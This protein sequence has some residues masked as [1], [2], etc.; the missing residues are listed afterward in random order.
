MGQRRIKTRSNGQPI[1]P[2]W[3][4][5]IFDAIQGDIVPR[6]SVGKVE[7]LSGSIGSSLFNWMRAYIAAGDFDCGDFKL[8]HSYNGAVGP[9]QG[10]MLCD[11]R[12]INEANYNTEHGAGSWDTY[13][14]SSPLDGKYLP[15]LDAKY[16]VGASTTTQSGA[17]P[18]T[19][20]GNAGNV[21][22]LSHNHQIYDVQG[23]NLAG[24]SYA[25]NNSFIDLSAV[26]KSGAAETITKASNISV[27]DMYT[28]KHLTSTEDIRPPSIEVQIYM[29]II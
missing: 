3:F 20:V 15:D 9:G 17:S 27:P 10:W 4:N 5:V 13:I 21:A 11:G 26:A 19:S 28:T 7:S 1:Y 6:N 22:D 14:V 18:I 12:V 29:R 2:A 25:S 8:H 24:R 16:L 23:N